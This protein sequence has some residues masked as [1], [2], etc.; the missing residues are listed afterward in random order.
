MSVFIEPGESFRYIR[1]LSYLIPKDVDK[2][3]FQKSAHG[4]KIVEPLMNIFLE[5]Q[6]V[7]EQRRRN[8]LLTILVMGGFALSFASLGYGFDYLMGAFNNYQLITVPVTV[9]LVGSLMFNFVSGLNE[10]FFGSPDP[11]GDRPI[12]YY[13]NKLI[14]WMVSATFILITWMFFYEVSHV[15][16]RAFGEPRS[17]F[18]LG[19]TSPYG[20]VIGVVLGVCASF[21]TLQWGAYSILRSVAASPADRSFD[22]DRRA[23][24]A[25]EELSIAAGIRSPEIFIVQDE[26]PNTFSIGRS[27]KHAS[28]VVSQGLLES[29]DGEEL[30]GVI[31]HEI[32]HIRSYD[33]R[34]RTAATALFGSV[35]LLSHWTKAAATKGGAAGLVLRQIRSGKKLLLLVFWALTLAIVPVVAYAVVMLTARHREYLADASAAELT[36]NP[37]AL[38][39]AM[40]KIEQSAEQSTVFKGSIAH[41]CIIDPLNRSL[42]SEE[43]WFADLFSTHPPTAKRIFALESMSPRYKPASFR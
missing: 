31:A 4:S 6:N 11:D 1:A 16:P 13:S 23:V 27:P 9:I 14:I 24:I 35:A 20:L 3:R 34:V 18:S 12:D 40:K 21:S 43:G 41:L 7:A 26:A 29:L 36:H 10:R 17:F 37:E 42:N 19:E 38:I 28:I 8:K 39:H 22:D 2:H 33:I 15:D 25:V 32:S 30:K 5:A